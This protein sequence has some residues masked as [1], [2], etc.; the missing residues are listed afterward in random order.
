MAKYTTAGRWSKALSAALGP[1]GTRLGVSPWDRGIQ[2][3]VGM[4][5]L[6]ITPRAGWIVRFE[7][8]LD[9]RL[10]S[11]RRYVV[12]VRRGFRVQILTRIVLKI[13]RAVMA[14]LSR[15][16]EPDFKA[17][18]FFGALTFLL[19][20]RFSW[21]AD[22]QGDVGNLSGTDAPSE[23]PS[24]TARSWLNSCSDL[25]R[26]PFMKIRRFRLLQYSWPRGI[27]KFWARDRR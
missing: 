20:N 7:R 23:M 24:S 14:V 21:D 26:P 19:E 11:D 5:N 4:E 13:L 8:L 22:T 27:S 6:T 15:S 18:D 16:P 25:H 3:D 10:N 1:I 12:D 2:P 17:Q 9:F